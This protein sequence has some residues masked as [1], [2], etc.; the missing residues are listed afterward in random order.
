MNLRSIDLNLLVIFD[1]VMTEKSISAAA[2]KVGMSPSAAS[3][4]LQRLRATF[5][6]RLVERTPHGMQ[7]TRR[8]MDLIKPVREALRQLQR[9]IG[10]KLV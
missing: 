3:H 8:A 4:A 6:D 7:P 9:G 5:N 10:H 2:R 1:A